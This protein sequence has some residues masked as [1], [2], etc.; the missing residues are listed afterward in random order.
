[1]RIWR[2]ASI[3]VPPTQRSQKGQFGKDLLC[4]ESQVTFDSFGP[5]Q[6]SGF[7]ENELV[8]ACQRATESRPGPGVPSSS[9]Q[10]GTPS[11]ARA[12][13]Q[14]IAPHTTAAGAAA[15]CRNEWHLHV[16]DTH[17][18]TPGAKGTIPICVF[19]FDLFPLP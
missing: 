4:R 13:P 6:K 19:L 7:I 14:V 17:S 9:G 5:K 3:I 12:V 18:A 2:R 15:P 8:T 16:S 1:M 10:A 11:A